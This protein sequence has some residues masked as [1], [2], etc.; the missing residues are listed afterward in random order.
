MSPRH[1]ILGDPGADSGERERM[2]IPFREIFCDFGFFYLL[3]EVLYCIGIQ[4]VSKNSGSKVLGTR[5]FRSYQR[6]VSWRNG[7]FENGP[8]RRSKRKAMFYFFTMLH[9]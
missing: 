8:C 5:L 3:N 4:K 7:T 2:D 6:S 9:L 1:A